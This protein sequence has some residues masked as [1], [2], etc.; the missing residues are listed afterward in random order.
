[1]RLVLDATR[2]GPMYLLSTASHTEWTWR[3]AHE[4]GSTLPSP[5]VCTKS[6]SGA[7]DT[8]CAVEPLLTVGYALGGQN[9]DGSTANGAQTLDLTVG[10]LQ[11]AATPAITGATVRFSTDGGTTWQD[12]TVT[13]GA[14][15]YRAAFPVIN[16]TGREQVPVALRVTA[17][18]AAG[19]SIS[20]TTTDAFVVN[21]T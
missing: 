11:D 8:A 1:M 3:S 16:T 9:V 17:T 20:E 19:G 14:G 18:D 5:L 12:A 4:Q 21:P 6:N 2:T 7:P 13:G 15:T 10:H